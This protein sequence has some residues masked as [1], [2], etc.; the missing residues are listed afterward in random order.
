M[1]TPVTPEPAADS[2]FACDSKWRSA[3]TGEPF[4]GE[5][6]SKRYCVLHFPG[7]EK[8]GQ[9]KEVF[10]RKKEQKNFDFSGVWVPEKVSFAE[11]GFFGPTF[12][13]PVNFREATFSE[14]AE[15]VF[16][17]FNDGANFSAA[18]FSQVADFELAW[19]NKGGNFS[20][21]IFE[22]EAKLWGASFSAEANFILATFMDY[23]SFLAD[24][25]KIRPFNENSGLT[26]AG[27]RIEKPDHVSFHTL[28]LR[29]HWFVLADPRKFDFINVYWECRSINREIESLQKLDLGFPVYRLLALA[30]TQLSVNA[31]ENN[32]YEEASRFRYMAMDARRRES[33]RGF[34]PWR[35]SWWYW[36][37]SGYGER[38]WQAA[39]VLLALWFLFA[40]S[41]FIGQGSGQWWRASQTSSSSVV[42]TGV[43]A[44]MEASPLLGFGEAL[45]YS[46]SVITLQKPEPAPSNKRAKTLVLL[47]TVL[48]PVQ[49][50]LLALAI[51]RK[52]MR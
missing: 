33:W 18:K 42:P 47:E 28:T 32:R 26:L 50:A 39:L 12:S 19:F 2:G 20:K 40:S 21:P 41:F 11:L 43:R 13:T 45:V 5:D 25:D 14:G 46:A 16:A 34:A 29:P 31:E 3:C 30:F 4:Y 27:A 48:G 23:L 49:A 6:R 15:F 44:G 24:G 17:T 37:A 35:L 36:L 9:F 10:D 7:K 22:A 38:A 51:R 52:F 1:S 8:T